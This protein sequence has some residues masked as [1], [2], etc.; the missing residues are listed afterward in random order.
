MEDGLLFRN[1]QLII[2]EKERS[3]FLSTLHDAHMGEEKSLLLART[4]IYWPHYTED[5]KQKVRGCDY[6]QQT[7]P[8]QKCETLIPYEP[9]G[10]IPQE[11]VSD[12]GTQFTSEQYA[13][14]AMSYNIT[15]S[16]PDI[17]NPMDL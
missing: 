12:Q 4:S 11:L 1:I 5:I 9:A 10:P 8:S 13:A 17:H 14:F 2:P 3:H 6:C 15:H 7:R 16:S